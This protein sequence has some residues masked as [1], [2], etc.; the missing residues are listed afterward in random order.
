[1]KDARV[2]ALIDR[3]GSSEMARRMI[4]DI[5]GGAR[6][7]HAFVIE[8]RAG[9]SRD[10]FL[11]T[12]VAGLQCSGAEPAARPCRCC[13][14]CRQ[15]AAGTSPDIVE[16]KRSRGVSGKSAAVYRTE[17]AAAFIERLGMGAYGHYLI[18]IIRDGDTMSEAV[19]NKILKTLEEPGPNT[20]IFITAANRD[21][22][23]DTVRSRCSDIRLETAADADKDEPQPGISDR[24]ASKLAGL[25]ELFLEENGHFCTFRAD[26]DRSVRSREEALALL[27][28][29]EDSLRGRM[30]N[31][32]VSA[33][34]RYAAC[35][36]AAAYARM[37]I[38]R[39][40][41]YSRALK[42]LYLELKQRQEP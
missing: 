27:D 35:I 30:M 28:R 1:M 23:L 26:L 10:D 14:S 18:G 37:D 40:M 22:L 13:P 38:R 17:D 12:L 25:A 7:A 3:E 21:E 29:L 33:S 4:M 11:M 9:E 31:A 16:M 36:E 8:G 15:I 19:Q 34:A 24:T 2:N 6:A 20:L 5:N 39:D 32:D 42:R 41:N